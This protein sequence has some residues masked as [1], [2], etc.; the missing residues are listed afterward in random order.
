MGVTRE[1]D[2]LFT[3]KQGTDARFA[4]ET[5]DRQVREGL[6]PRALA[7]CGGCLVVACVAR[8]VAS[9]ASGTDV[10]EAKREKVGQEF[11]V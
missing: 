1:F 7:S 6:R 2:C 11:C 5:T 10:E 8:F 3:N 9:H 4:R